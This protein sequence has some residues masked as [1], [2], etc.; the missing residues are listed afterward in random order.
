MEDKRQIK[1]AIAGV[2]DKGKIHGTIPKQV[3]EEIDFDKLNE[4]ADT[5][6]GFA[7]IEFI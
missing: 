7:V 1:V 5:I 3:R 2:T 6:Q 4:E